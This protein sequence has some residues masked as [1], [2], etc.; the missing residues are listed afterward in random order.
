MNILFLGDI[1]G[2]RARES[3]IEHLP[4]WRDDMA[5]DFVIVNGENAAGGFG[6]TA[7]ICDALY[8]AGVDIITLGNH[9]WDQAEILNH[10][11]HEP[12]LLRPANFPIGTAGKGV[13]LVTTK[14]DKQVLVITLLG[15]LFME[16]LNDPFAIMD[17][18][19]TACP[20]GEA[21]DA[22]IVEFHGEASSEKMAAGHFC[23]G[24]ET[25]VVGSHTHVPTADTQILPHGTAYQTDA[26]MCG[27][28]DSV[29][30]MEKEEPI[31]RFRTKIR[32]GRL[33][34]SLGEPSICGVFVASDDKSGLAKQID[35]FRWG[36]R[37]SPTTPFAENG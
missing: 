6:I 23:D 37:L 26:G 7:K 16:T 21:A 31:Y 33:T 30:G 5:L 28:Y 2:R 11:T 17:K 1:V 15:Q 13:E 9:A 4:Q 24:R 19:L 18:E 3:V 36:G 32:R 22:I 29:I 35:P 25:L 8:A 20:L 14:G 12:R 10:I 34:P 27:D